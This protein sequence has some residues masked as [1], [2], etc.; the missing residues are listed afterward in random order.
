VKHRWVRGPEYPIADADG[1]DDM[2][3]AKLPRVLLGEGDRLDAFDTPRI[4][5]VGTRAATP[6]GMSDA[7]EIAAFCARAGITVISG[8]AIGI[9]AAAHEGALAAGGLTVGVVATG[10]DVVYPRRHA[11]LYE[12]VKAQGLIVAENPYGT[13]PLPWRFPIRNRIIAALADAVVIVEATRAGGALHTARHANEFGR[14]VYA[15][16]GSRRN[17]AAAGCNELIRD[18][19]KVLL[20]PSDLLFSIGR[21]GEI[22]GGWSALRPPPLDRDQRTVLRAMAGDAAT[23]DEIEQRCRLPV[24]RLGAALRAL[25]A[26]RHIERRRGLWWPGPSP[27]RKSADERG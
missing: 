6:P 20:E 23:T 7:R 26:G 4:A 18:G 27:K 17:P 1:L 21:G 8:L 15:L 22:D 19:A 16:P 13:Q 11:R 5:I 3:E 12:R 2:R 10:L 14:D 9:D 25:E 24:D